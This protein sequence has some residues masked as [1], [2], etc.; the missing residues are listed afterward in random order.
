[1]KK[2]NFNTDRL[3]QQV[4]ENPLIAAGVG[5]GFLSGMTKLMNANTARKNSSTWRREV[6]RRE[7]ASKKK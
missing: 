5:L 4:E 7:G 1:M 3:K 6:R 2:L